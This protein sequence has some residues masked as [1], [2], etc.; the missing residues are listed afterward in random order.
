MTTLLLIQENTIDRE[1]ENR[2]FLKPAGGFTKGISDE[3]KARVGTSLSE[4]GRTPA[5]GWDNGIV[6]PNMKSNTVV[7]PE[8]LQS[9]SIEVKELQ[10]HV[11][12]LMVVV[13]ELNK[14]PK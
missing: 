7:K 14:E 11:N 5:E 9:L 3:D 8:T 6:I 13:A 1:R 2:R 10:G 12:A 4:V